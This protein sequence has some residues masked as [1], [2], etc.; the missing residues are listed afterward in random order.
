MEQMSMNSN[1]CDSLAKIFNGKGQFENG[2]CSVT[3]DRHDI[4][5]S[6]AAKPFRALHHMFDFESPDGSGNYLITGEMVLLENEVPGVTASL[7]DSDIIPSALHTHWLY[8]IPKL[9]YIHVQCI[10]N[11]VVF[12]NKMA[13][14]LKV[15]T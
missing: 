6:I 3:V 15:R 14:I 4:N 13:Q 2:I 1:L 8:D 11:P 7:L 12:A 9:M 10:M 5:A